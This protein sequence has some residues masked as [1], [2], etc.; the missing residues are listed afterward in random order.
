MSSLRRRNEAKLEYV[1]AD[2][3]REIAVP[4]LLARILLTCRLTEGGCWEYKGFKNTLGYGEAS[5]GG[6]R[7]MVH[8]YVYQALTNQPVPKGF[9]ICHSCHNRACVNPFH[10]RQDTHQNNLLDSSRA[11]R[12]NGQ[13]KTHCKRGHALDGENLV[14]TS[15]GFRQCRICSRARYRRRL[16]WPEAH[17]YTDVK[18]PHGHYL[19][20]ETGQIVTKRNNVSR[21]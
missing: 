7:H 9:D 8:R 10:I 13:D 6:K 5:L 12:L 18:I 16:G 2:T 19:D 3:P 15:G 1:T 21:F 4:I 11:K 14:I 17:L 20:R